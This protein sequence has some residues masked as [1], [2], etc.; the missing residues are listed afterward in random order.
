LAQIARSVD[1]AAVQPYAV[2]RPTP[3]F[4]FFGRPDWIFVDRDDTLVGLY[5]VAGAGHNHRAEEIVRGQNDG[6]RLDAFRHR[7]ETTRIETSTDAN[8]NTTTRTVTERHDEA[9]LVV[10][11]PFEFG[12]LNVNHGWGGDKVRF[13]SEP[14]N[15]AFTVRTRDARF[16]SDVI[17]PRMMELIMAWRPVGFVVDGAR[18]TF[19]VSVHDQFLIA[20]C[21]DFAHAFFALVPAFVWSNLRIEPPAFRAVSS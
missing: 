13:E 10:N 1:A 16:A 2:P 5:G 4:T 15:D 21:A 12:F 3:G 17:H 19:S 8:G 11:L 6:L 14:F 20:H 9:I 7:W 18:L